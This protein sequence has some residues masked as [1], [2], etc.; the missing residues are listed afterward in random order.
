MKWERP[1]RRLALITGASS[2]IGRAFARMLA[3][4]GYD[5]AL[6]ARRG[7]RLEALAHELREKGV[8]AFALPKDISKLTATD[9]LL[10]AVAIRDRHVDVLI[11]NAGFGVP[12]DYAATSWEQQHASLQL[13]LTSVCEMTHK[14]LPGML[15]RGYG[16]IVNVASVAGLLP[17][18]AGVNMYGATNT[19]YGATKSFLIRF[20]QS[21]HVETLG[22]GV[23]VTALCPGFT[24]SEFHD[25]EGTRE[26]ATRFTPRWLWSTP[27]AVARSGWRA[28]EAGRPVVV[29]GWKNKAAG[30][31][32][33]MAPDDLV[34]GALGYKRRWEQSRRSLPP[35]AEAKPVPAVEADAA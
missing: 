12:G 10:N 26:M 4:R 20:S 32:A 18:G 23:R 7:P 16:R 29:P 5:V 6:T 3:D 13:M 14:V 15:E 31:L 22:T 9:E 1:P 8:A 24:L 17:G 25:V 2:G 34:L 21:L 30:A 33:K 27:E 19:L 35:P 11:N 28:V